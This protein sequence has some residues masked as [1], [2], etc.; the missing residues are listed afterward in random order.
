[1]PTLFERHA[2]MVLPSVFTIKYRLK[3]SALNRLAQVTK[4]QGTVNS[5]YSSVLSSDHKYDFLP[6]NSLFEEIQPMMLSWIQ[7]SFVIISIHLCRLPV[8][9]SKH[10]VINSL[11]KGSKAQGSLETPEMLEE[12]SVCRLWYELIYSH[13]TDLC[14]DW[15]FIMHQHLPLPNVLIQFLTQGT[16]YQKKYLKKDTSGNAYVNSICN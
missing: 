5:N 13:L 1:M 3:N 16:D 9:V 8:C 14:V 6:R 4:S 7:L 15:D 2:Y 12:L 10:A 11:Y